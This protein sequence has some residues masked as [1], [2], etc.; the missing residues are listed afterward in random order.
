[1]ADFR[2]GAGNGQGK[3]KVSCARK[4]GGYQRLLGSCKKYRVDKDNLLVQKN[5]DCNGLKHNLRSTNS[6][7]T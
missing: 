6:Y 2:A 4:Q 5:I 7:N 1:M 3:L